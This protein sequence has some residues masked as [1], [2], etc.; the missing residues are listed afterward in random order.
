M[1]EFMLLTL[2]VFCWLMEAVLLFGALAATV[3]AM[4]GLLTWR[5]K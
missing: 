3:L 2:K 5:R 1:I 4:V